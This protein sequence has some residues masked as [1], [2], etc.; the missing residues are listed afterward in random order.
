LAGE[1]NVTFGN[2]EFRRQMAITFGGN[3]VAAESSS[4]LFLVVMC[5]QP[6]ILLT[7]FRWFFLAAKN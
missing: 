1:N 6:K 4:A 5:G 3:Y 7:Y 2:N